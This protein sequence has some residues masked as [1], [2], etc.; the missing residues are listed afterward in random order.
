MS[1]TRLPIHDPGNATKAVRSRALQLGFEL[2]GIAP[3]APPTH[4]DYF[5]AWLERGY[6]GEMAY[7]GRPDSVHRRLDP[8]GILP[9]ARTVICVAMNYNVGDDGPTETP[10][11]PVVS[12]YAR[13]ADYH[14][15]FEE[16]LEELAR[17][18][19]DLLPG[20]TQ[21][22]C[23]VD[24]GPVL[25]RDHAQRAGIGWIG[26]NTML[27]NPRIGSY[28]FL[29][30]IITDADLELD[31]AF[32]P[33]H[34][35]TCE[36][37]ITAC[38]TGAICGPR[39]L[40]ARLCISYLTIELRGPIPRE[41]RPLIGN[42][43]FGCDICQEVCPWNSDAPNTNEGRFEPRANSTGSE[44]IELLSLSEDQ[45]RER[46]AGTPIARPKRRGFLR[47]VAVALGNWGDPAAVTP[48]IDALQDVEPLVRGHAAWALGEIGGEPAL[49]ALE[50]RLRSEEDDWV[51]EEIRLA[52]VR[53]TQP[54]R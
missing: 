39:E 10:S 6:G 53:V 33:D 54:E 40:D 21:A 13:G 38:P 34:C 1:G 22:R 27:I 45:F 5:L 32:L 42:R 30:E 43:V 23:Y 31:D 46:F 37:C 3:A 19:R 50:A 17:L 25:E 49:T 7:L 4:A 48:L 41:L 47:N 16:K 8:G 51:Q 2:V 29:G 28:L 15:V 24:Y 20:T 26:K 14:S 52:R 18:L 36:R 11:R 35:G 44:L 12:R 9:G